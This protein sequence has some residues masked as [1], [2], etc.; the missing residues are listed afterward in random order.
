[1]RFV[2]SIIISQFEKNAISIQ[3]DDF[4][5]GKEN[6]LFPSLSFGLSNNTQ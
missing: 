6:S 2:A 3:L 5:Y 4:T 1:M